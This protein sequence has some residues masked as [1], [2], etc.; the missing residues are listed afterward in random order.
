MDRKWWPHDMLD[1]SMPPGRD[2]PSAWIAGRDGDGWALDDGDESGELKRTVISEGTVLGFAWYEDL[3]T[4]EITFNA[5]G[6]YVAHGLIPAGYNHCWIA[7]DT[8]TINDDVAVLAQQ[9]A[10]CA[11]DL[12]SAMPLRETV[13]F[14]RWS[15]EE[16]FRLVVT[17]GAAAFVPVEAS[18]TQ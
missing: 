3:A 12:G 9:Q 18:A 2:S 17:D 4:V 6:S 10:E 11:A 16:N 13:E 8:D 1:E 7:F 15:S 5:D 14:G